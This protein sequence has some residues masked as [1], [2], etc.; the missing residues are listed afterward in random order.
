MDYTTLSTLRKTHPAWRLLVADH[1]PMIASFLHRVF[2]VSNARMMAQVDLESRIE[3]E[4]F[5]LREIEGA[6]AFPRKASDYLDEWARNDKGWLRK[7]YPSGSDEAC[8]DLTP[9]T[10][11]AIAWLNSLTERVFIGTESRLMTVFELLRQMVVGA[12][13]DAEARISALE[14]RKEEID[15]EIERVRSGDFGLLDGTGLKDRFQQVSTLARELLGDF[16]EVEHNF[17]RLDRN[18]REEI[19]A[20]EGRKG[21][22]LS[23]IFG[24]RDAIADSDQGK[25]FR[26]FWDFLMSPERQEELSDLLQKVFTL[27]AIEALNPDPRLKRI[28]YDWLEAGE[29]TQRTVAK[30]S[31]QLRRFLDDKAYLENKR[32]MRLLQGIEAAALDVREAMP[33]GAFMELDEPSPTIQLTME[34]PLFSPPVRPVIT[35]EVLSGDDSDIAVDPLFEQVIV[36][37]AR[38]RGNIERMLR[39]RS[40]VTL[41]EVIEAHPLQHGLTEVVSYLAVAGA[42]RKAVFDENVPERFSWRDELGGERT[43]RLPRVIFNR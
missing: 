13:T 21:E 14:R 12:E 24:E 28:H 18:V 32:I 11:K 38:L 1:A 19:A 25:S 40:Q 34:R 30:L 3:D 23:R 6:D 10:E 20:W 16:R 2:I 8:F 4:L 43:A 37:M 26:A 42:D 15:R 7:F 17:R 33:E 27:E 36:D 9:A 35:G 29:C 31:Q 39:N 5:H 41:R 22:L